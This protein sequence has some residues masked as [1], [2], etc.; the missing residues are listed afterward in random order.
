MPSA[1]PRTWRL[2][3]DQ[4]RDPSRI[5]REAGIERAERWVLRDPYLAEGEP[6]RRATAAFLSAVAGATDWAAVIELRYRDPERVPG[7]EPITRGEQVESL[8]KRIREAGTPAGTDLW[9]FP[10]DPRKLRVRRGD[11]HDRE[12]WI[13]CGGKSDPWVHLLWLSGGVDR[14]MD[15]SRERVVVYT[16]GPARPMR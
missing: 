10:I 6:N 9:L 5:V 11:F 2:E 8:R 15:S 12:L 4:P 14:F 3:P 13:E 16:A 1:A 7:A